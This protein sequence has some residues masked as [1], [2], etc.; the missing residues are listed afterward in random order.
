MKKI[1][2]ILVAVVMV[3]SLLFVGAKEEVEE[4]VITL[5]LLAWSRSPT[6]M[7][8][9]Q[10]QLWDLVHEVEVRT[11]GKL[12]FNFLGGYEAIPFGQQG[13]ALVKGVSDLNFLC[14]GFEIAT[15]EIGCIMA[16]MHMTITEQRETG[17]LD[18]FNEIAAELN[19]F[20][21]TSA[22]S[23]N[24]DMVYRFFLREPIERA[25]DLIG[26]KI[27]TTQCQNPLFERIGIIPIFMSPPETYTAME[28]GLADGFTWPVV[29]EFLAFGLDMVTEYM[30]AP[31]YA[32]MGCVS[33]MFNLDSWNSLPQEYRDIIM[34]V[35]LES[36]AEWESK[37][38]DIYA[39]YL[40]TFRSRMNEI[41]LPEEDWLY[42]DENWIAGEWE[43]VIGRHPEMQRLY[44]F[45]DE[46]G[47]LDRTPRSLPE[48]MK[49]WPD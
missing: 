24:Y 21:L 38:K 1:L 28:R 14:S 12:K 5:D 37:W 11:G 43:Y 26:K 27:V 25:S 20:Y 4:E 22:E 45:V 33:L 6:A 46:L 16:A 41:W 47:V 23:Y 29:P 3:A 18:L 7:H 17:V 2:L 35:T 34:E 39:E 44:D 48:E 10:Q 9:Q 19:L 13:E 32:S 36:E 40:N 31:G 8:E 49:T 42:Y 30:V 15:I